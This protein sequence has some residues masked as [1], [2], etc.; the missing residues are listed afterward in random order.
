MSSDNEIM[1]TMYHLEWYNGGWIRAG[2]S[3][4][5]EVLSHEFKA[6]RKMGYMV[7]LVKVV[8]SVVPDLMTKWKEEI[9]AEM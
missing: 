9:E 8:K 4:A 3:V 6:L 5:P 1:P 2:G 7:R